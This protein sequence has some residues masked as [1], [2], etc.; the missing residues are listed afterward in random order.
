MELC[1]A[2]VGVSMSHIYPVKNYHDEVHTNDGIDVLI[3]K[4]LEQ[5]VKIANDRLED[6]ESYGQ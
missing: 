5:I 1:S 6:G 2:K 4:A 3:P